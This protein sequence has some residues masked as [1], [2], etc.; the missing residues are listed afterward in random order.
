ML[1]IPPDGNFKVSHTGLNTAYSSQSPIV[2]N[3]NICTGR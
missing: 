1:P 2:S 3:T